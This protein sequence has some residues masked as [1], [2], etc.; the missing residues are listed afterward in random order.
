MIS[1]NQLPEL[2][3]YRILEGALPIVE[4]ARFGALVVSSGNEQLPIHR[5]FRFKEAYSA[6]LIPALLEKYVRK[7]KPLPCLILTV[8]LEQHYF[9]HRRSLPNQ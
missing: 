2:R 8:E 7:G 1:D 9:R 4:D 3:D 5:W 6:D